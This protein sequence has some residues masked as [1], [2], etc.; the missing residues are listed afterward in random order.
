[1]SIVLTK[2]SNEQ[3]AAEFAY[4]SGV[5]ACVASENQAV[6][7]KLFLDKFLNKVWLAR[8]WPFSIPWVIISPTS[9]LYSVFLLCLLWQRRKTEDPGNEVVISHA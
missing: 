6:Q 5:D 3:Q 7:I 4:E 1:M 9:I 2:G 8:E